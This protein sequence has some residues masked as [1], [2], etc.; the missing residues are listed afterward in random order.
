MTLESELMVIRE[1]LTERLNDFKRR[2]L[3]N[4]I[5]ALFIDG[6]HTEIKDNL[7]VRKA[8][9]YNVLGVDLQG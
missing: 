6:Y 2:E 1:Q 8:C 9:V 7:K 5:F 3:P 4:D